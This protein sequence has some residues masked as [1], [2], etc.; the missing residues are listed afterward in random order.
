MQKYP[1]DFESLFGGQV[2]TAEEIDK[3]VGPFE[4]DQERA[5]RLFWLQQQI[6]T[7]TEFT[8]LQRKG[9][10]VICTHEEAIQ[11]NARRRN[12]GIAKLVKSHRKLHDVDHRQLGPEDAARLERERRKSSILLTHLRGARAEIRALPTKRSVPEGRLLSAEANQG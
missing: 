6:E 10:L 12:S 3:H 11:V 4:S 1:I 2:L 5:L 7:K 8:V 9:E